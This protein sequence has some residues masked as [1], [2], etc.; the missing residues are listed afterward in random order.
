MDV[1]RNK[2]PQQQK[3]PTISGLVLF[4]ILYGYIHGD[5][6]LKGRKASIHTNTGEAP[7]IQQGEREGQGGAQG[8]PRGKAIGRQQAYRGCYYYSLYFSRY[9]CTYACSPLHV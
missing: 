2:Q 1:K 5:K 3:Q 6:T 9:V 8:M 7:F 4:I